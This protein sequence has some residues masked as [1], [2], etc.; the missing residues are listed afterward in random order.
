MNACDSELLDGLAEK[1]PKV[2]ILVNAA[3]I[4]SN[5]TVLETTEDAWDMAFDVNVKAL[6]LAIKAFIPSM[7]E[8]KHS[9]SS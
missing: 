3:S 7:A 6:F 4:S 8:V 9:F 5:G 2:D 1:L